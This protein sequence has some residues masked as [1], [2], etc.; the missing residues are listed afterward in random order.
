MGWDSTRGQLVT[1]LRITP[2][3]PV[4]PFELDQVRLQVAVQIASRNINGPVPTVVVAVA[5]SCP[6]LDQA[7]R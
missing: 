2:R 6:R 4:P 3:L 7:S 1:L 5:K